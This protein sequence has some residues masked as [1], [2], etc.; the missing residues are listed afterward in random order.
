MGKVAPAFEIRFN[1]TDSEFESVPINP[2]LNPHERNVPDPFRKRDKIPRNSGNMSEYSTNNVNLSPQKPSVDTRIS[3]STPNKQYTKNNGDSF[4]G[5]QLK[6]LKDVNNSNNSSSNTNDN[7]TKV[8]SWNSVGPE[9]EKLDHVTAGKIENDS[10]TDNDNPS[11]ST[12][13]TIAFD[14]AV[15]NNQS[16]KKRPLP[17]ESGS[18]KENVIINSENTIQPLYSNKDLNGTTEM[19]VSI[20]RKNTLKSIHKS[21]KINTND[22]KDDDNNLIVKGI[23]TP[24]ATPP[25]SPPMTPMITQTPS[26]SDSTSETGHPIT[27]M[28]AQTPITDGSTSESITITAQTPSSDALIY[29]SVIITTLTTQTP[30]VSTF[31]KATNERSSQSS[32]DFPIVESKS[33]STDSQISPT[34]APRISKSRP[35]ITAYSLE[36]QD[37]L[38]PDP[39][40]NDEPPKKTIIS[41]DDIIIPTLAKKL[42]MNGQLPY[43]NH[44]ALLGIS[45]ELD[46]HVTPR[47][48]PESGYMDITDQV[49]NLFEDVDD[50]VEDDSL[51][52]AKKRSSVISYQRR[53]RRSAPRRPTRISTKS[54]PSSRRNS[55]TYSSVEV[56]TDDTMFSYP[57]EDYPFNEDIRRRDRKSRREEFVLLIKDEDEVNIEPITHSESSTSTTPKPLVLENGPIEQN[58]TLTGINNDKIS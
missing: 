5:S 24:P 56:Q 35:I 16:N 26:N 1:G 45:D 19:V 58:T 23:A 40:I 7:L 12:S 32:D 18:E 25:R 31:K 37:Q 42:K 48:R 8:K 17:E 27:P 10:F 44:E 29:D 52:N 9:F 6:T 54:R 21:K 34:R 49:E 50:Q 41:H 2:D 57:M 38:E 46:E 20:T 15:R 14:S 43:S 53:R 36:L 47:S 30:T 13:S 3:P 55:K 39:S 33:T 11:T 4:H 51:K 22:Y 28:T